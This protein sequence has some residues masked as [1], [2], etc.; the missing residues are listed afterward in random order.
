MNKLSGKVAIITGGA[1]GIGEASV[2]EAV[3]EGAYVVIADMNDSWGKKLANELN[4]SD[5]KVVYQHTDVTK[6]DEIIQLIKKAVTEFGRLDIVFNNAGIGIQEPSD[7][8]SYAS[9]R[10]V[11]AVNLDG[12]FLVAKH[13][14]SQMKKTGGGSI[15]NN[16]SILGHVGFPK[17]APY[18]SAKGGILTLTKGLALEF[19][20][21][22]I[23]VNSLSPAFI[24]TPLISGMGEEALKEL[25]LLHP[26][27]RLGRPEEVAKAFVF[28]A[29]DDASFI[30]G[31]DL[32]V[33]GGYTAR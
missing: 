20:K 4:V 31:T 2:R 8:L 6:E 14:I 33:D 21:D 19:A 13:A 29:S 11:M 17:A 22:N 23:R 10:K 12:I 9:F 3:S 24:K 1:S 16:A 28:L 32:L 18:L 30:T 27:G 7:E 15:V 25:E 5:K 26:I